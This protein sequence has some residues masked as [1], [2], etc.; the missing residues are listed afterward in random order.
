MDCL[1]LTCT[2]YLNLRTTYTG[3]RFLLLGP[4][5]F[6]L[7][8]HDTGL[9]AQ[10]MIFYKFISLYCWTRIKTPSQSYTQQSPES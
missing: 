7:Q 2:A 3:K 10:T 8:S 5:L 9:F 4:L 1:M 6:R